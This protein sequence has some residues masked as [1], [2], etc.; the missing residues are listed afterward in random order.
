M[1]HTPIF[2]KIISRDRL[3]LI[4]KYLHFSSLERNNDPLYKNRTILN[5]FVAKFKSN[6]TSERNISIDESPLLWKGRLRWKRFIPLKRARF[7]IESFVLAETQTGYVWN[8]GI[9]SGKE[10]TY[11]LSVQNVENITK[12]SKIVLSLAKELLN[13]GYC[14]GMDNYCTMLRQKYLT[15]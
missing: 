12:P 15:F 9:Y 6:C 2:G 8:I 14:I 5:L 3:K 11:Q 4:L 7:G 10:K 1:I 13:K